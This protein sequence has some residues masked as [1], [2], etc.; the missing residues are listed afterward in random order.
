MIYSP[1]FGHLAQIDLINMETKSI[2]GYS[3]IL[4]YQGHLSGSA[5]VAV[6]RTKETEKVGIKLIQIILSSVIPEIFQSDNGPDFVEDRI[7]MIKTF[8]ACICIVKGCLYHP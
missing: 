4:R 1:R 8:Y 7:K 6:C 3:Y 5:H 2:Q